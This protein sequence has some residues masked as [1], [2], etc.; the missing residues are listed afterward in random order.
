MIRWKQQQIHH[1]RA[2]RKAKIEQL[3][4]LLPEQQRTIQQLEHLIDTLK[5]KGVQAVLEVIREQQKKAREQGIS[6]QQTKDGLSLDQVFG[7]MVQQIETGLTQ[8][9]EDSIQVSLLT[10]LEETLKTTQ[11]VHKEASEELAKLNKEASKKMTSE[12]IFHETANRTII[13]SSKPK[14]SA[15]PKKKETVIE[16]LNPGAKMKDLSLGDKTSEDTSGDA[17]DETDDEEDGKDIELTPKA[18]AFSKLEG[19]PASYEFIL[20]NQ[21]IVAE[22]YSDQI[23]AEAF[24][25]QLR[26]EASYARNC[27]IQSLTLQYCGQLGSN[28]ISVFFQRMQGSNEQARRMFA[29]DVKKTYE[30]IELRCAE[31]A[32]EQH[33]EGGERES[34]QL[35]PLSEGGQLTVRVPK[36]DDPELNN[37]EEG[38]KVLEVYQSLPPNFREALETA[39]LDTINKAL[40]KMK[41][42]DAEFV[43]EVCSNYGFLDVSGEVIDTTKDQE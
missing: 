1:E 38:K 7:A 2:E 21:D 43:I 6:Q 4:K 3:E 24:T 26:G 5:T 27:V 30:R 39:D 40:D 37:S 34:I 18:A 36:Q 19:F 13:N 25:A 29:D 12:N 42:E 23:L 11:R 33:Y 41:V 8:S 17:D 32:Q 10:R 28:G 14:P 16:T 35:Q 20:K 22:K 31:I 9:S 15:A